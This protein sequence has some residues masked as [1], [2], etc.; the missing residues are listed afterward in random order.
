M[1]SGDED[2]HPSQSIKRQLQQGVQNSVFT[3]KELL[4]SE[5]VINED[6]IVGR[7]E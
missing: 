1:T 7:D 2:Q 3:Q 6:R 4:D 5:T